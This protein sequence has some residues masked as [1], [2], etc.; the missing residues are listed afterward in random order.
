MTNIP[1]DPHAN[2]SGDIY[3]QRAALGFYDMRGAVCMSGGYKNTAGTIKPAPCTNTHASLG[4]WEE[5]IVIG[6]EGWANISNFLLHDII[7]SNARAASLHR[8]EGEESA[9]AH[10]RR[11]T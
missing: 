6:K 9:L 1:R 11:K 3:Q 5:I 4:S 10:T 8:F 7:Q 2:A